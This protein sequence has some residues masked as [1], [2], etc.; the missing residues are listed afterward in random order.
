MVIPHMDHIIFSD[1]ND[2]PCC[3]QK[4]FEIENIINLKV[5]I[6]IVVVEPEI[7]AWLLAGINQNISKKLKIPYIKDTN[8]IKKEDFIKMISKRFD[9]KLDAEL[10]ILKYFDI[11]L[12]K[13]RNTSFKY[14]WNKYVKYR[15]STFRT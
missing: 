9:S 4:R 12:A 15:Q 6:R 3:P 1:L 7:E 2:C 8:N 5:K 13:Q 10:E 11:D 14:F